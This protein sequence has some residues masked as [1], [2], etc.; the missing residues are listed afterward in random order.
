[1]V[2]LT[3]TPDYTAAQA[4]NWGVH[5]YAPVPGDYDGDDRPTHGA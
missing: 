2:Q 3:A 5:G 4:V 1:M